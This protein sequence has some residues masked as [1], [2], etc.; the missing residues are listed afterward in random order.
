MFKKLLSVLLLL[1]LTAACCSASLAEGTVKIGK[2]GIDNMKFAGLLPDGRM[3]YGGFMEERTD[4]DRKARLL[5]LN[6]D[7]TVSWEY[8]DQKAGYYHETVV[9]DEGTI[10]VLQPG[11]FFR[12]RAVHGKRDTFG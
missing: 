4:S 5:C 12:E 7:G 2:K 3:V 1:S 10:A 9:T 8:V 6:P 11:A